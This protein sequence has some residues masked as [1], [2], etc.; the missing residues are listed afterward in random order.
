MPPRL[1]A[2]GVIEVKGTGDD[3]WRTAQG[4]QVTKYRQVL[5]TYYRDFVLVG[6]DAQGIPA[7]LESFRMAESESD[8]WSAAATP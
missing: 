5:V 6:Q 2:C 4:Q 8:F 7:K 1:P 3:A